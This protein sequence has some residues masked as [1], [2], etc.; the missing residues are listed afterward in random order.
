ML[1][2]NNLNTQEQQLRFNYQNSLEKY[3]VTMQNVELSKN[4]FDNISKKY[5]QGMVSSMD[6]T[7]ANNTYLQ[8]ESD[9]THGCMLFQ[10]LF[11]PLFLYHKIV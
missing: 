4:I 11:Y 10:K 8:T 3:S 2:E 1:L 5:K 6:L 7:Q 9:N